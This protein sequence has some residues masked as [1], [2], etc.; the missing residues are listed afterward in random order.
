MT[1]VHYYCKKAGLGDVV[2]A[3]SNDSKN[4]SQHSKNPFHTR[5]WQRD[6]VCPKS[7]CHSSYLFSCGN[8]QRGEMVIGS[9]FIQFL[10]SLLRLTTG[11]TISVS[12]AGT[13]CY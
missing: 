10:I 13:L 6:R 7:H 8:I 9:L 12:S 4:P 3:P 2:A 11:E 1:G 5:A